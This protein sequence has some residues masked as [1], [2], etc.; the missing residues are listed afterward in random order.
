MKKTG[1]HR[2]KQAIKLRITNSGT[3]YPDG[4][5]LRTSSLINSESNYHPDQNIFEIKRDTINNNSETTGHRTTLEKP[6]NITYLQSIKANSSDSKSNHDP[7]LIS[8]L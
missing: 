1:S 8:S 3:I 6:R 7:D 4:W 2:L 5:Q